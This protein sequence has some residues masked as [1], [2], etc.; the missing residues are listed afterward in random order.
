MKFSK[1]LLGEFSRDLKIYLLSLRWDV[2]MISHPDWKYHIRLI[3]WR[4]QKESNLPH[5]QIATV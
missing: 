2:D 3:E 4:S 5:W 1:R